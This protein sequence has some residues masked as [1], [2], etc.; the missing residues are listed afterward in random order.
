MGACVHVCVHAC[1]RVCVCVRQHSQVV[2]LL[3]L[4]SCINGPVSTGKVVVTSVGTCMLVQ[5]LDGRRYVSHST[6]VPILP[7]SVMHTTL[8]DGSSHKSEPQAA[9]KRSRIPSTRATV[10]HSGCKS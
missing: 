10:H 3:T 9:A 7:F 8:Q 4:P 5:T 6:W 1:V 2:T